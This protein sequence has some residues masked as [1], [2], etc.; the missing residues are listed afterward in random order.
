MLNPDAQWWVV[1]VVGG[2][3]QEYG[4]WR[5]WGHGLI[6]LGASNCHNGEGGSRQRAKFQ[7][8]NIQVFWYHH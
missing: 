7:V 6:R 8:K 3:C 1:A 5:V 2:E 4:I